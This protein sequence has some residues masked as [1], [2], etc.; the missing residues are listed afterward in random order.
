MMSLTTE[1]KAIFAL[2]EQPAAT[3]Q[4]SDE[5]DALLDQVLEFAGTRENITELE[6]DELEEEED[7]E[8]ITRRPPGDTLQ[9]IRALLPPPPG[10]SPIPPPPPPLR[11]KP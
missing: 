6:E 7:D 8:P 1:D 5:L 3:S 2:L 4:N 10:S 9:R 11:R